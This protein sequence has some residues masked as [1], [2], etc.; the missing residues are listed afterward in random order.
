AMFEGAVRNIP[1]HSR[2]RLVQALG[3]GLVSFGRGRSAGWGQARIDIEAPRT[4]RPLAERAA[5]FDR[6]LGA[7]LEGAGLAVERPGRLVPGTLMSPLWPSGSGRD[8]DDDGERDL[9]DALGAA[10]RLLAARRFTREG[11]WDQRRGAMTAFQ[12]TAAGGVFVLELREAT[13]RDVV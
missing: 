9:C 12:A 2:Q 5:A 11:A 4:M 13:W 7:R 1:V 8:P 3:S 6:A 10:V